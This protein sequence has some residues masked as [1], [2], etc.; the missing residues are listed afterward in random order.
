MRAADTS[1]CDPYMA[2]TTMTHA[3]PPE[4]STAALILADG[5]VFWGRGIGAAGRAVGEVC[6]YTSITGFQE[7]LTDPSFAG[8]IINFSFQHI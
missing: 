1:D 3:T 6:F 2:K 8:Q 7:I 5:S 4:G